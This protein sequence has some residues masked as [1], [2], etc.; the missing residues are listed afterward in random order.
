MRRSAR[1]DANQNEIVRH[2]RKLGFSVAITS[3][4]GKGFPDLVVANYART[5]LV[6]LKDGDKP[7]SDQ[8]LTLDET[9]FHA[10][11]KGNLLVANKLD[12]ILKYFKH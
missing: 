1:I 8:A 2:L 6:E 7:P 10:K 11:W 4:I 5:V 12:D 9:E 3:G